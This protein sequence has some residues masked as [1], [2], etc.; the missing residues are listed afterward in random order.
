MQK[1]MSRKFYTAFRKRKTTTSTPLIEDTM[2][3]TQLAPQEAAEEDSVPENIKEKKDSQADSVRTMTLEL[4]DPRG[5]PEDQI[6]FFMDD[7]NVGRYITA[8]NGDLQK[9]AS[10]FASSINF[11]SEKKLD[12]RGITIEA[13]DYYS[14]CFFPVGLDKRNHLIIYSNHGR[15]S[16]YDPERSFLHAFRVFENGFDDEKQ[17]SR[18]VWIV[19]FNGFGMQHCSS[20]HASI[21]CKWF[22]SHLPERLFQIILLDP[23][24]IFK[25]MWGFIASVIDPDSATKIKILKKKEEALFFREHFSSSTSDWLTEISDTEPVREGGFPSGTDLSLVPQTQYHGPPTAHSVHCSVSQNP[26][27]QFLE[28]CSND[29]SLM[30]HTVIRDANTEPSSKTEAFVEAA[31]LDSSSYWSLDIFRFSGCYSSDERSLDLLESKE[32]VEFKE[33]ETSWWSLISTA[34]VFSFLL[35]KLP[36]CYSTDPDIAPE[37]IDINRSCYRRPSDKTQE[38]TS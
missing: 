26:D 18:C 24:L 31:S 15:L 23:P 13:H 38:V 14:N 19:D 22:G 20:Q 9:A 35:P 37:D 10:S 29:N 32:S 6:P 7:R 17:I 8:R 4:L 1:Q 33:K 25:V 12:P 2:A 21:A 28:V 30:P 16:E 3:S 27:P 11:R 5:V 34:N 36:G